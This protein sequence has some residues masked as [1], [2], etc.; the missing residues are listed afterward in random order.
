LP[1]C[2]LFYIHIDIWYRDRPWIDKNNDGFLD[3]LKEYGGLS[4]YRDG[5]NVYPA[6]WGAKYDWLGLRQRQISQAKR[7]SYYH[8]I[9]NVEIEQSNNIE[10]ID[11]TNRE[12]MIQNTAFH[13]LAELTKAVVQYVE[14]DYMGKREELSK[15][16]GG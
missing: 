2:G 4:I 15:L 13:D 14:L 8:M 9:G 5:I 6:E 3:Y 10:L 1:T 12:G 11:K 7:I 16:T